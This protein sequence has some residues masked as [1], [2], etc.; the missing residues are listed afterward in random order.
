MP[1]T[2]PWL[3]G[4]A[5]KKESSRKAKSGQPNR[6]RFSSPGDLVN[7]DLESI[8]DSP[9]RRP[10]KRI[11]R[12]PSSSPP[13]VKV[14]PLVEYMRDGF[15]MDDRYM[16]VEDE[17][18]STANLFSLPLHQDEYER[19]KRR[20]RARGAE[21]LKLIGHGTDGTTG[22][23]RALRLSLEVDERARRRKEAAGGD[24]SGDEEEEEFM[25]DS[26]LAGLMT[27]SQG[28]PRKSLRG[29]ASNSQRT[30]RVGG[31]RTRDVVGEGTAYR[32]P[33]ISAIEENAGTEDEDE[34][35][36]YVARAR[37]IARKRPNA[38]ERPTANTSARHAEE[39]LQR[40]LV[41]EKPTSK[42]GIFKQFT[43]AALAER[44]RRDGEKVKSDSLARSS[45]PREIV[46]SVRKSSPTRS[47]LRDTSN[48]NDQSNHIK[49]SRTAAILARRREAQLHTNQADASPEKQAKQEL[50]SQ[51]GPKEELVSHN[52]I[53]IMREPSSSTIRQASASKSLARRGAERATQDAEEKSVS[54]FDDIPTFL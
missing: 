48:T 44:E 4:A 21:T 8:G 26:H 3:A 53:H 36:A 11:N 29:Y 14:A 42:T 49:M 46:P 31:G 19:T 32:K 35:D 27:A 37:P 23:S 30:P 12:G 10:K 40:T 38:I 24:H 15:A 43:N 17:F 6:K 22:Q 16:M 41:K 5:A 39:A 13:P 25:A 47:A 45:T 52:R 9:K 20:A 33:A 51:V 34:L 50:Q 1:R 28:T 54:Q 18:T 2:L 7:S